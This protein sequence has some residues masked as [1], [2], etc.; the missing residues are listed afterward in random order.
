MKLRI[1]TLCLLCSL[2]TC[3]AMDQSEGFSVGI[4]P[5]TDKTR[6]KIIQNVASLY[7]AEGCGICHKHEGQVEVSFSSPYSRC[8]HQSCYDFIQSALT[9]AYAKLDNIEDNLQANNAHQKLV[10]LV[11]TKI[12]RQTILEFAQQ[13]GGLMRLAI[14]FEENTPAAISHILAGKSAWE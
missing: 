2:S 5:V 8:A 11:Q 4:I 7:S 10:A 1:A 9:K 3:Y 6:K 13:E 12:G 14:H